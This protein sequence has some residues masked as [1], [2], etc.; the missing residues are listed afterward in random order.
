MTMK[1]WGKPVY[2]DMK[3]VSKTTIRYATS[4]LSWAI[5]LKPTDLLEAF[6]NFNPYVL[7]TYDQLKWIVYFPK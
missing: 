5:I 3:V 1:G 7:C 6:D 4:R 2:D